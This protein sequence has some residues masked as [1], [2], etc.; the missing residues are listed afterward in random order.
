MWVLV[1]P[2]GHCGTSWCCL[3]S[4]ADLRRAMLLISSCNTGCQGQLGRA[5]PLVFSIPNTYLAC[6]ST[7]LCRR[8]PHC[9]L[10]NS[11]LPPWGPPITPVH[12]T[13][14]KSTTPKGEEVMGIAGGCAGKK[15]QKVRLPPISRLEPPS[16]L[17][18]DLGS[19]NFWTKKKSPLP[20]QMGQNDD[21]HGILCSS[22]V[23]IITNSSPFDLVGAPCYTPLSRCCPQHLTKKLRRDDQIQL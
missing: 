16:K 11:L 17:G 2:V 23:S 15:V 4:A 9:I 20:L 14:Q 6:I 1:I 3:R 5:T 21:V 18:N 12:G 13:R 8:P 22:A 19:A 7:L 10:P